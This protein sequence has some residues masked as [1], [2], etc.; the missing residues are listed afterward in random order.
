MTAIHGF[1]PPT[2]RPGVLGVHS[3]DHFG[4]AVPDVADAERFYAAFG[5]AAVAQGGRLGLFTEGGTHRWGSIIEGPRKAL[6]HVSFGAFADDLPAFAGHLD[7]LGIARTDPPPGTDSNGLWFRDP[8]GIAVEIRAAEKVSPSV[9][10]AFG[11][12]SAPEGMRGAP[13]RAEAPRA[14]PRRLSHVLLFVRDVARSVQFYRNALG[15]RLSDSSGGVIAFMHGVHGSDHHL[16]AFAQSP[17]PGLHHSSWD[18]GSIGAIGLGAIHMAESG[19][20]EG[21]GLGRH[22]IGS[23]YFHYVRDPWGSYAEYAADIDFIPAGQDWQDTAPAPEDAFTIW[24]PTPP[25][26]FVVNHEANGG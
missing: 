7:R 20:A 10:P 4:L 8:D 16:L 3:L 21:W 19:F 6:G 15:L 1:I 24:G 13:W 22:V 11:D 17:A 14:R 2:R 23:N 26:D 12:P 5:L 9:K 25:A 18:M